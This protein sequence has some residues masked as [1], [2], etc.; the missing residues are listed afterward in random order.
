MLPWPNLTPLLLGVWALV[1]AKLPSRA[2]DNAHL[3][4]EAQRLVGLPLRASRLGCAL[5][6]FRFVERL[7]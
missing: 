7:C 1:L 2:D 6:S 3:E 4:E 5:I